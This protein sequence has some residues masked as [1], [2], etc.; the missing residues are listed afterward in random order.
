MKLSKVNLGITPVY[1][2]KQ[3]DYSTST[4]SG[5][6]DKKYYPP[7]VLGLLAYSNMSSLSFGHGYNSDFDSS[8]N[9]KYSKEEFLR[10][11]NDKTHFRFAP[12]PYQMQAAQAEFLNHNL[13]VSAPTGTGKTLIAEY[14]IRLALNNGHKVFYCSPLKAL[15]N[16]QYKLFK[17]LFGEQ[18]VGILTGD[19]RVNI[20]APNVIMT[21]EVYRNM[22]AN[23]DGAKG[24]RN[25][26]S[27]IF[28]EFHY[29]NNPDRGHVWEESIMLTPDKMGVSFD[30]LS[31]T[32]GNVYEIQNWLQYSRTANPITKVVDVPA[33]ERHVPLEYHFFDAA[34]TETSY[35]HLLGLMKRAEL[36]EHVNKVLRDSDKSDLERV[37]EID[38][39]AKY[40]VKNKDSIG[41]ELARILNG[42]DSSKYKALGALARKRDDIIQVM[43]SLKKANRGDNVFD[44]FKNERFVDIFNYL[45]E[46]KSA[47][48]SDIDSIH[49]KNMSIAP[50]TAQR[51]NL[52]NLTNQAKI[53][54]LSH[55]QKQELDDLLKTLEGYNEFDSEI[56]ARK[57]END[58]INMLNG[59]VEEA[60]LPAES[61]GYNELSRIV[62]AKHIEL[63]QIQASMDRVLK[64][65]LN[66][67]FDKINSIDDLFLIDSR[68]G[69]SP[70]IIA[71]V[72]SIQDYSGNNGTKLKELFYSSLRRGNKDNIEDYIASKDREF[73][74]LKRKAL[75]LQNTIDNFAQIEEQNKRIGLIY[76]KFIISKSD[77][78]AEELIKKV[79]ARIESIDKVAVSMN[80]LFKN[81]EFVIADGSA[82]KIRIKKCE[83]SKAL[84][85]H[86]QTVMKFLDSNES[87][88]LFYDVLRR[89]AKKVQLVESLKGQKQSLKLI[90]ADINQN[91]ADFQNVNKVSSDLAKVR[92]IFF[93]LKLKSGT[94]A[95]SQLSSIIDNKIS[96]INQIS[97]QI[98]EV[99][100]EDMPN[101]SH[102]Q[103]FEELAADTKRQPLSPE[104]KEVATL[105]R[106]YPENIQSAF[107]NSLKTLNNPEIIETIT[108]IL[109]KLE[110]N[111][112]TTSNALL[113]NSTNNRIS[114]ITQLPAQIRNMFSGNIPN[115]SQCNNFN[116][117]VTEAQ[118][119]SS[120]EE[121]KTLIEL[122]KKYPPKIQIVFLNLLKNS[123]GFEVA[124]ALAQQESKLKECN[125]LLSKD[126]LK[127]STNPI[128]ADLANRSTENSARIDFLSSA[129][130]I[131]SE[132]Q[133]SN[134]GYESKTLTNKQELEQLNKEIA[135]YNRFQSYIQQKNASFSLNNLKG[136]L[137]TKNEIALFDEIFKSVNLDTNAL[138]IIDSKIQHL[139]KLQVELGNII[140]NGLSSENETSSYK[141]ESQRLTKQIDML[142]KF[143]SHIQQNNSSFSLKQLRALFAEKKE[144][145]A[146][147]LFDRMFKSTNLNT[148]ASQTIHNKV[149]HLVSRKNVLDMAIQK[150]LSPETLKYNNILLLLGTFSSTKSNTA[151]I[152]EVSNNLS[153][154][155]NIDIETF[156]NTLSSRLPVIDKE[157]AKRLGLILASREERILTPN[158]PSNI[159]TRIFPH[160]VVEHLQ[161]MEKAKGEEFLPA[162]YFINNK[163]EC[164]R[165]AEHF[166]KNKVSLLN[167]TEQKEIEKEI[168]LFLQE[169]PYIERLVNKHMELDK[170]NQLRGG[171]GINSNVLTY[172]DALKQGI[173]VHHRGLLPPFKKLMEKLFSEKKIKVIFSTSTLSAGLNFPAKT[174]IID[175]LQEPFNDNAIMSAS[176]FHQ[177]GGRAG[178]R[179]KDLIGNVIVVNNMPNTKNVAFDLI[180]SSPDRLQSH[181]RINYGSVLAMIN[182]KS[183]DDSISIFDKSLFVFQSKNKKNVQE[184]YASSHPVVNQFEY[185]QN[186]LERIEKVLKRSRVLRNKNNLAIMDKRKKLFEEMSTN[187]LCSMDRNTASM[188]GF[189]NNQ[190]R[191][192]NNII[193]AL[194]GYPYIQTK[195]DK[196]ELKLS[197]ELIQSHQQ[198]LSDVDAA[199]EVVN[200][201]LKTP[202][203]SKDKKIELRNSNPEG[204]LTY[205]Q[206]MIEMRERLTE[207]PFTSPNMRVNLLQYQKKVLENLKL[208]LT[209]KNIS[210]AEIKPIVSNN[211]DGS[212][213]NYFNK[214]LKILS[215][216]HKEENTLN[217]NHEPYFTSEN[218]VFKLTEKGL[219][220]ARIQGTNQILA[221]D[222]I[223]GENALFKKLNPEEILTIVSSIAQGFDKER[224]VKLESSLPDQGELPESLNMHFDTILRRIEQI[225][226]A[227]HDIGLKEGREI[228]FNTNLAKAFYTLAK[229]ENSFDYVFRACINNTQVPS[230]MEGDFAE[231]TLSTID[232]LQQMCDA[233]TQNDI[234]LKVKLKIAMKLLKKS[235]VLEI[236]KEDF[237]VNA[238]KFVFIPNLNISANRASYKSI[239]PAEIDR[240]L[241]AAGVPENEAMR[242]EY[243]QTI[244]TSPASL[245]DYGQAL[246]SLFSGS[247]PE[248]INK[249]ANSI[250][251]IVDKFRL[252][253][254][255]IDKTAKEAGLA[256]E[257]LLFLISDYGL[258]DINTTIRDFYN[259]KLFDGGYVFEHLSIEEFKN[260]LLSRAAE[261]L[262]KKGI[263]ADNQYVQENLRVLKRVPL[264]VPG[265]DVEIGEADAMIYDKKLK[266]VVVVAECKAG[267]A[268]QKIAYGLK[269]RRE[270]IAELIKKGVGEKTVAIVD[271]IKTVIEKEAFSLNPEIHIL[272]TKKGVR[273]NA[274]LRDFVHFSHF[275]KIDIQLMS[276]SLLFHLKSLLKYR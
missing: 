189:I 1:M 122:L 88:Q 28:D 244:N 209:D 111:K 8:V 270:N 19:R 141:A 65:P 223:Y 121:F 219:A 84:T 248:E 53:D 11:L 118:K 36:N 159:K 140:Q 266:K 67:N 251:D 158:K 137:K 45:V 269:T 173:G 242:S 55:I 221:S 206:M 155:N 169:N 195:S 220:A 110:L 16:D 92:E 196:E 201:A 203:L 130:S 243:Y 72:N 56:V 275:D 262:T 105:L 241:K 213:Y 228:E 163:A 99:F 70:K 232:L 254:Y 47:I 274:E 83:Q 200:K 79:N 186:L 192:L 179:G 62:S 42:P 148:T 64:Q 225:E 69:F 49:F 10:T 259:K 94:I 124:N 40:L 38:T 17:Q 161:K 126:S 82:N 23:L 68:A 257:Q 256:R 96:S 150:R 98:K 85:Q 91:L 160:Q 151:S 177:E 174:V 183:Y 31:A 134:V 81:R 153:A 245:N 129:K 175:S 194:K 43:T 273:T 185:T 252:N 14:K 97:T 235:P 249:E 188:S 165:S 48:S 80:E 109:S 238:A 60:K 108:D 66:I 41:T 117:L 144:E 2:Y 101:L 131:F 271:G 33:Y 4:L 204:Y 115:I 226:R 106:K 147:A 247:F 135:A 114:S 237:D 253:L 73:K 133:A 61:I 9:P 272:S 154:Y 214:M 231:H 63:Q 59:L 86:S 116:D 193:I 197:P 29:I 142:N 152:G 120:S 6:T 93:D 261:I 212:I 156:A 162:I 199:L 39:F 5:S 50:L 166:I 20:N 76:D 13:I 46:K 167:K 103:N 255:D 250:M 25:L 77:R 113:N 268:D 26:E 198:L 210:N 104:F 34:S 15:A 211:S 187:H 12:D 132:Y 215:D 30:M 168:E 236:F 125:I 78:T 90:R 32:M 21:T 119:P 239:H 246:K 3:P 258:D 138:K 164:N 107:L 75:V 112:G 171:K 57:K 182:D 22:V 181:L 139:S 178:R 35:P 58:A 264:Y 217:N 143:K 265:R 208:M 127:A 233:L 170:L 145:R 234:E 176:L 146:I 240:I 205:M 18:N 128:L 230:F 52:L 27:I 24:L 263:K 95:H 89:N 136:L 260:T 207:N 7:S 100:S 190:R 222:L 157:R 218:G 123:N 74:E 276:E 44:I 224:N 267:N 202:R 191:I 71:A 102:C 180:N 172:L 87:K 229:P 149:Q 184:S 216:L 37:A 54:K 51:I 227:Q